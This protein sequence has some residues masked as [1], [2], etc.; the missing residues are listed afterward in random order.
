MDPRSGEALI[1]R[2]P[3]HS[4]NCIDLRLSFAYSG[5]A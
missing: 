2:P 5:G 4:L 1:A 3:S